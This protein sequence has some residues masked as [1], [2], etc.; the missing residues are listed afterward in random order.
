MLEREAQ[1]AD[2]YETGD[3]EFVDDE[4]C[5]TTFKMHA[6]DDA[7]HAS[8]VTRNAIATHVNSDESVCDRLIVF[9]KPADGNPLDKPVRTQLG[10]LE[11]PNE[12]VI[13]ANVSSEV[14]DYV[15][16]QLRRFV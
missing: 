12:I 11:H 9:W 2:V 10:T 1:E 14:V 13:F 5:I 7:P 4:S 6:D 3:K 15:L 8:T 16:N